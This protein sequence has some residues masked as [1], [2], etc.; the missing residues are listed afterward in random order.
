MNLAQSALGDTSD[1]FTTIIAGFGRFECERV[2][3]PSGVELMNLAQS[4]IIE[5]SV[6]RRNRDTGQG[7]LLYRGRV[8]LAAL[9]PGFFSK[10]DAAPNTEPQVWE[11]WLGLFSADVSLK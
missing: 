6:Q 4:A 11:S 1:L 10:S 5:I 8:P 3:K 7:I 2:L 9:H